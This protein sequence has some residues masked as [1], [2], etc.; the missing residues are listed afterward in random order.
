MERRVLPGVYAGEVELDICFACHGFWFDHLEN[1]KLAPAAVIEL[2]KAMHEHREAPRRPLAAALDCPTCHR[3]LMQGFDFARSGRFITHRCPSRHGRFSSFT[4]FMVEKGFVRQLT[5]PEI[6]QM[7]AK[8]GAIAC[9]SCGA[10]VDLRREDACPHCR[11]PLTL[12]DPQAVEQALQRLSAKPTA[13]P[14]MSAVTEALAASA[15]RRPPPASAAIGAP[16]RPEAGP[17]LDV[18][19]LSIGLDLLSALWDD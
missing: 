19:L 6:A 17:D 16:G 12:L 5:R 8:V 18:D 15:R 13:V 3:A 14:A 11:T 10:P 7:A 2:F 9:S 4:A 1:L